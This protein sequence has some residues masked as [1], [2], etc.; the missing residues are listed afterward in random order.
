MIILVQHFNLCKHNIVFIRLD[1]K[2]GALITES[3]IR[4]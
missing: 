1:R 4:A 2:S 3:L